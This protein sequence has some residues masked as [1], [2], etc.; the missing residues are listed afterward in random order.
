MLEMIS[1]I[2]VWAY[3]LGL[4]GLWGV[5][6]AYRWVR[7][8]GDSSRQQRSIDTG[9]TEPSSLHPIIDPAKC[10]GCSA[11][12]NACPEGRIIGMISGKAH[13]IDPASCI[14]HGACKTACPVNAIDL[15]FGTARRGVDIPV[16]S[17]QFESTVP[18]IFIAGE[19][20]GMGLIA[21]AIEQGRQAIDAIAKHER[22]GAEDLYDVVIVGGGPAGIAASLAAK[23]KQ[24]RYLTLEQDTLGGTVA[25][26]PRSKLVMTRPATLPLYGKMRL[27][28]IRKERLIA[29]WHKVVEETGIDIRDGVRVEHI[30]VRPF[31]FELATT[32]GACRTSTVLLATGRRG[33][34]RRLGV[35]GEDLPK[36]VYSL[37]DASQYKGQHIV[38]V[39]GGDSAVEAATELAKSAVGSVTL[40]YRRSG[41]DRVKPGIRRKL[42]EAVA[43]GRLFVLPDSRVTSIEPDRIAI[44]QSGAQHVFRNDGVIVCIGGLLPTSLLADIGVQ[45]ETKYGTA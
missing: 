26:Y 28:R 30:Q 9:S 31:G 4:F 33:S 20:G 40:S 44:D 34:P 23:E 16:V 45:V 18:G 10:V 12:T 6:G 7:E 2:G 35:P 43:A 38:V 5:L 14:G 1:T 22:I 36:V 17:A 11:C 39:G 25:R 27:R 42:D 21:N 37:D 8:R 24:L 13:L 41:F 29:F 32:A 15:V 3:A 19:L